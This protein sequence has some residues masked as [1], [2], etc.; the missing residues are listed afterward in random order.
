M[1]Q[2]IVEWAAHM[3]ELNQRRAYQHDT[4]VRVL[5]A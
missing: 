5:A 1:V 4:T 3:H 2:K